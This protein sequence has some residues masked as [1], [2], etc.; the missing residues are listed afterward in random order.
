VV[1]GAWFSPRE[2]SDRL[3]ITLRA[4]YRI[5]G[6]GKLACYP[7]GKVFRLRAE[8]VERFGSSGDGPGAGVREPRRPGPTPASG[9]AA[10]DL[11]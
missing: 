3:G 11:L 9:S 1:S 10:L 4:L 7:F 5:I 8:D 2:A 6:D